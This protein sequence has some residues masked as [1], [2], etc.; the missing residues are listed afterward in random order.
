MLNRYLDKGYVVE[1]QIGDI[2][3]LRK[4][5]KHGGYTHKILKRYVMEEEGFRE[6]DTV[7]YYEIVTIA[8]AYSSMFDLIG[9][10][11]NTE[12]F[13]I[14]EERLHEMLMSKL[15]EYSEEIFDDCV[16]YTTNKNQSIINFAVLLYL[17]GMHKEHIGFVISE[18]LE[19][20]VF[21]MDS[22]DISDLVY[23]VLENI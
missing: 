4:Y 1:K 16:D 7:Q 5:N 2:F 17:N 8:N 15:S 18:A 23:G 11:S 6:I 14:V 20:T 12:E 21:E 10:M 22:E 13:E 3:D 9:G 19:E